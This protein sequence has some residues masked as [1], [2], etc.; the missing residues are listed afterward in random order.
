M[1]LE[2]PPFSQI[3]HRST[4]HSVL[5][6]LRAA[7]LDGTLKAGERIVEADIARQMNISRGPVREALLEL[8]AEGLVCKRPYKGT[9][10]ATFSARDIR[11]IY[12]LRGLLE[13][14]AAR[15]AACRVQSADI[16]RLEA[17][18]EQM[19]EAAGGETDD[20]F[21]EADIAF[22]REICRLSGHHLLLQSWTNLVS[23]VRLFLTLADQYYFTTR[24]LLDTHLP[25]LEALRARSPDLAE[26]T[27]KEPIIEVGETVARGLGQDA[28]R[29]M[30]EDR[31]TE[32]WENVLAGRGLGDAAC[33]E[34]AEA[35]ESIDQ[36]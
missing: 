34:V 17:I 19:R 10:V 31:V 13:G 24:Y 11:E 14:Y 6:S 23:R 20:G 16:A 12:S 15:L 27:I 1:N 26:K 8:E 25:T 35:A 4:H 9:F 32:L 30:E 2:R 36:T 7:I 28:N 3:R 5:A 21:V 29:Q 33:C 18:V 22:H